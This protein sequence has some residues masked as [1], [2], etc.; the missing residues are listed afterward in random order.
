MT[1]L[2]FLPARCVVAAPTAVR[3][4]PT[5]A[6]GMWRCSTQVEAKSNG[7]DSSTLRAILSCPRACVNHSRRPAAAAAAEALNDD[8]EAG[9]GQPERHAS[10]DSPSPPDPSRGACLTAR[11]LPP[12]V[13]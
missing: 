1:S 5:M 2:S 8:A 7:G 4:E 12:S 13:T 9:A 10:T 11:P 3:L 6:A